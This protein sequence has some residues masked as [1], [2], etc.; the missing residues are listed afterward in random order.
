MEYKSSAVADM[1][2]RLA[3]I[4]MGRKEGRLCPFPGGGA[5]PHLTQCGLGPWADVCLRTKWHLDPSSP[6]ATVDMGYKAGVL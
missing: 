3:T 1:G 4:D 5:G 6:L 2:D